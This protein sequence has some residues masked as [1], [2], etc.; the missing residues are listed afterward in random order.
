MEDFYFLA[1]TE[2]RTEYWVGTAG[3]RPLCIA[4]MNGNRSFR[5]V[6]A[7]AVPSGFE[8]SL[9]NATVASLNLKNTS[10]GD[11]ESRSRV[12][13]ARKGGGL[14]GTGY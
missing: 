7:G 9:S 13:A 11:G 14:L 2:D 12:K 4:Q 8:S 5:L 6:A 3:M 10:D 1:T